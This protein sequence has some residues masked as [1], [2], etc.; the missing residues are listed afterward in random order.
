WLKSIRLKNYRC[1]HELSVDLDGQLIVLAGQNGTGKTAVLDAIAVSLSA[2][3]GAFHFVAWI[4]FISR[5]HTDMRD[6]NIQRF[7]ERAL[8]METP[9]QALLK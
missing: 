2:F 7:G 6:Q 4:R 8:Q 3:A 5:M 1:F 9:F